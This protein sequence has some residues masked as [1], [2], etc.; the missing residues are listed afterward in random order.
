MPEKSKP[1][2]GSLGHRP[3]GRAKSLVPKISSWPEMEEPQTLGFPT[4]KA[5]MTH[6]IMVDDNKGGLKEGK[7][8]SNAVTILEA[9]PVKVCAVRAYEDTLEGKQVFTEA[10]DNDIHRDLTRKIKTLPE[11]ID[12]ENKLS[13]IEE[14]LDRLVEIRFLVH[15]QPDLA[16]IKKK[17]DI[18]EYKIGGSV[19]E[20]FEYAKEKLGHEL[21]LSDVH[22]PGE[23]ID[24]KGV[25]KGKGFEGIV[26]R[27]GVRILNRKARNVGRGRHI[28]SLGPWHPRN[29]M[30]TVPM[31]GQMGF[32]TRT[33]LNKRILE[34]GDDGERVTPEGG[35]T[36]YGEVD[37]D[38]IILKGSVPGPK[39]RLIRT[40]RAIRPPEGVSEEEPEILHIS[41]QS[42]QGV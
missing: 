12:H 37:N 21:K 40:R 2:S 38:Y 15:T 34:I 4:Y 25:T 11:N 5:G 36:N 31:G 27:H 33:E 24:V 10:W 6:L 7:E 30:W 32:H 18:M 29:V 42:D 39:K 16:G 41:T 26:K 22:D 19:K 23:L 35:F 14:N 3:K 9:P 20:A 28:G 13:E 8:V 17:P 1:R